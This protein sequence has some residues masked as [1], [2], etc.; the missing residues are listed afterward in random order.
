M[1]KKGEISLAHANAQNFEIYPNWVIRKNLKILFV[2]TTKNKKCENEFTD[3]LLHTK[4]YRV[5]TPL[6]ERDEGEFL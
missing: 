4:K 3:S 2:A 5:K 6:G 1:K